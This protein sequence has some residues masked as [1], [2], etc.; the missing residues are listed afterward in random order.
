[1]TFTYYFMSSSLPSV[2]SL[3]HPVYD[4]IWLSSM[5]RMLRPRE[6]NQLC[7]WCI[8]CVWKKQNERVVVI[9]EMIPKHT[10]SFLGLCCIL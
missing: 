2:G 3:P 6:G 7:R 1:M 5:G 9:P 10:S 8:V 4:A